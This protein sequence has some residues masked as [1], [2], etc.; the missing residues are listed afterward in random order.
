MHPKN[1]SNKPLNN[2]VYSI[3]ADTCESRP[4]IRFEYE[5]MTD[6]QMRMCVK[7]LITAFR[8][9]EVINCQTGEVAYTHY[10]SDEIFCPTAT[11]TEAIDNCMML[12]ADC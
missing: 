3:I 8:Q 4:K 7:I 11:P 12:I 10:E 9:V 6:L 5:R 2:M 1:I